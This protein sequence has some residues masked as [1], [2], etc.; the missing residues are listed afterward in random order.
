MERVR[1]RGSSGM[2]DDCQWV[3]LKEECRGGQ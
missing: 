2:D 1:E 3:R